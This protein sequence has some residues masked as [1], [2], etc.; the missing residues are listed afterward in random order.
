MFKWVSRIALGAM[1]SQLILFAG[2]IPIARLFSPYEIGRSAII[3]S[4]AI[5]LSIFLDNSYSLSIPLAD[6]D[7]EAQMLTRLSIFRSCA[8]GLIVLLVFVFTFSIFLSFRPNFMIFIEVIFTIILSV[9]L[10]I[11]AT[12]RALQTR[13][14]N[15]SV[16]SLSPILASFVQASSQIVLGV[17][18]IGV[19]GLVVGIILGKTSS[20]IQMLKG[21]RITLRKTSFALL[22]DLSKK[23]ENFTKLTTPAVLIN[24]I[25][26]SAVAP[27]V[28][29]LFDTTTAGF[30]FFITV[31]LSAPSG[32]L[33]QSVA[34]VLFP[35]L[36]RKRR[37]GIS[38]AATIEYAVFLLLIGS[39]PFFLA[40]SLLGP[41]IVSLLFGEKW[42]GA[43]EVTKYLV[44]WFA[45]SLVSSSVSSLSLV[46]RR[47]KA[48]LRIGITESSVRIISLFA[49][50]KF[51]SFLNP[52]FIYSMCGCLI[53]FLW[54][55]WVCKQSE[56]NTRE[57][58]KISC[59]I[60]VYFL[61][62]IFGR[63]TIFF[64]TSTHFVVV[65][66]T[67]LFFVSLVT[68]GLVNR[69]INLNRSKS[70]DDSNN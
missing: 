58:L 28:S 62:M 49:S 59:T 44:P 19:I 12:I 17:L 54:I 11:W 68:I 23:W 5:I 34:S 36:A 26:V 43:F 41:E 53:S 15:F 40:F 22:R 1:F 13:N 18:H 25:T 2:M 47:H 8:G 52:F 48:I 30:Y 35:L 38:A 61:A 55:L 50:A 39:A 45:L 14:G 20:T 33:G 65:S 63:N 37:D 6:T 29:Y 70:V 9:V 56:V 7:E 46:N 4:C 10:V 69:K 42:V 51:F 16:V 3:V 66:L 64:F 31:I 24:T 67:A 27:L 21:L 32:L 57:K 60:L